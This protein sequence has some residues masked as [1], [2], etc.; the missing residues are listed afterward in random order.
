MSA[1]DPG[2][3]GRFEIAREPADVPFARFYENYYLQERPVIVAGAGADWPAR[4]RWTADYL[5]RALADEPTAV[6]ANLWYWMGSGALER[7]YAVPGIVGRLYARDECLPRG[8]NLR[9]W[10]HPAGNLTEWHND[11]NMVHI[12]YVQVTGRK[13]WTL[14]SP[15]TPP[16]CYPFS[17]YAIID[18]SGERLLDGRTYTKF[19]LEEGDMLYLPPCWFHRVQS[20]GAEN[21]SMNWAMTG[22]KTRVMSAALARELEIYALQDRLMGSRFRLVRAAFD[23]VYFAIPDYLRYRWNYAEPIDA[24]Y[25]PGGAALFRRVL[26]ELAAIGPTLVHAGKARAALGALKPVRPLARAAGE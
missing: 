25:V 21:I 16:R 15:Q 5:A 13:D 12:F 17:Y 2:P 18:G 26:A 7:D 19:T 14:L 20:R 4:R 22:R 9:I 1:T 23:K 8:K 24:P 6:A 3:A 10:V 11:V